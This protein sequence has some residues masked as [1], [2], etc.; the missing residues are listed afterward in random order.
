MFRNVSDQTKNITPK[1]TLPSS[2]INSNI[3]FIYVK[4]N[5]S[6]KITKL[7]TVRIVDLR[8]M[9]LKVANSLFQ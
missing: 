7:G 6:C 4:G 9:L 8:I 3:E 1:K 5:A 2:Y